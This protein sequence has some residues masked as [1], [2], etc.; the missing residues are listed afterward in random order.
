MLTR[1]KPTEKL[2]KI[3]DQKLST[4]DKLVVRI[5][6]IKVVEII[7][8]EEHKVP[9]KPGDDFRL[10]LGRFRD[11]PTSQAKLLGPNYCT[12]EPKDS[13]FRALLQ[14]NPFT[15]SYICWTADIGEPEDPGW[16]SNNVK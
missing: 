13:K 15:K 10:V 2:S 3:K 7:K 6:T 12:I 5:S 4:D 9:D 11:T 16:N 8:V 14:F 1:V